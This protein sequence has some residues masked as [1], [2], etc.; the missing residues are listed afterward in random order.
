[1]LDG[2]ITISEE[3]CGACMLR[4]TKTPGGAVTVV[5]LPTDLDK[6]TTH[7][8]GPNQF[9]LCGLP[10]PSPGHV[11]G[12]L[13]ANGIGKSTALAILSGRLKPNFGRDDPPTW[14]EIVRYYR[15]SSL[16]N[17]LKLLAEG[18]LRAV[19]KPQR[20]VVRPGAR[21]TV[22]EALARCDERGCG[23][24]LCA[25]LGLGH[26]MDRELGALSGGERQRLSIACT[27]SKQADVYIFDEPCSFLDIKQRLAALRVIRGLSTD[28][29]YVIV[30][31]HD[32]A[33][34]DAA[35]DSICCMFGAPGAYGVVTPRAGPHQA[36][37]QFI[38]GY[39]PGVNMRFRS[40]PLDFSPPNPEREEQLSQAARLLS[41]EPGSIVLPGGFTLH[42]EG[43]DL[44]AGQVLGLL[45]EN[46][47]GKSTLLTR[48][49]DEHGRVSVKPQ[50]NTDL[51]RYEGTVASLLEAEIGRSLGDRLFGLMVLKPLGMAQLMP[52]DVGRLSGGELQRV[53]IAICLGRPA[54]VF[55]LDEP[56]AGLD[57]EQRL[58][59]THVIQRW[60]SSLGGAA[61]VV[62]HDL[63]MASSLCT[64]VT[65]F[66]GRPGVECTAH[67]P[68]DL[69]A[70]L[71]A[72]LTL[73][74]V[75]VREDRATGRPRLNKRGSAGD[76]EQKRA[77]TYY[78]GRLPEK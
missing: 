45:G 59:V 68:T 64:L 75:T 56:S 28:Q 73:L 40:Q 3:A 6:D 37:N 70:G 49:A 22:R 43:G 58:V 1:M 42:A 9:K 24:E 5:R 35:S 71:N 20:N 14:D 16:Q 78:L 77:E 55:M 25:E 53:A 13:G 32:L 47:C 21:R 19:V 2:R 62:E 48:L 4:A 30:V 60:V 23:E 51:G 50:M 72:F 29:T 39:F 12:I 54:D 67:V 27:A 33:I 18:A 7:R 36:I 46:G 66:T 44:R 26:L 69:L 63:L 38:A 41:L 57:C 31:E 8:Y 15:G 61:V 76:R 11:L 10:M 52:Y 74:D 17:Y 34:L 65:N